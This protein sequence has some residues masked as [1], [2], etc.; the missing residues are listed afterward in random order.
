[1][2]EHFCDLE[3]ICDSS[4]CNKAFNNTRKQLLITEYVGCGGGDS[5]L[6]QRETFTM[7]KP[8]TA[9]YIMAKFSP[10]E[11]LYASRQIYDECKSEDKTILEF[12]ACPSF[13]FQ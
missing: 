1:M 2:I 6:F 8:T 12:T 9:W 10:A 3:E 4:C 13:G 5:N 11:P 7:S